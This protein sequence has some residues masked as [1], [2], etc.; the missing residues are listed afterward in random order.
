M[1]EYDRIGAIR[2]DVVEILKGKTINTG[3]G[4]KKEKRREGFPPGVL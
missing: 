2:Q 4:G 3:F 1:Q